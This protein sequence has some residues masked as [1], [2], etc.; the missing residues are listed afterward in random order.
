MKLLGRTTQPGDLAQCAAQLRG[1]FLYD[2]AALSDLRKMWLKIIA[3]DVGRSAVVFDSAEPQRVLAFG[4]SLAVSRA[5]FEAIVEKRAPFIGRALLEECRSGENPLLLDS[6]ARANGKGDLHLAIAYNGVHESIGPQFLPDALTLLSE[7]FIVQHAGLNLEALVHEAYGIPKEIASDLGME[8]VAYSQVH[9]AVLD[10]LSSQNRPSLMTMSRD[11]ARRH[12]GNLAL[13]QM[14]LRFTPPKCF[15]GISERRILR[16]A[17][18]G[19]A[20][21]AIAQ[22]LQIAP[23]TL[24]KRWAAIYASMEKVIERSPGSEMGQR[25]AEVRRHVLQ[26]IRRHPE[27]LHAYAIEE[28]RARLSPSSLRRR[29]DRD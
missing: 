10:E 28:E 15:L 21:D 4:V 3:E 8:F 18:E 22:T 23:S 27:E 5:R 11:H 12:P 25:G 2:E 14:F 13:N 29:D 24:K 19:L 16:F 17:I 1:R 7:H 26:Y 6:F 9:E 20:D